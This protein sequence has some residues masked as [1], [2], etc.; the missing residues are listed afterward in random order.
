MAISINTPRIWSGERLLASNHPAPKNQAPIKIPNPDSKIHALQHDDKVLI[1]FNDHQKFLGG[2]WTKVRTN[3]RVAVTH[4]EGFTWRRAFT[5]ED[6]ME[7]GVRYSYPTMLVSGCTLIVLY[8]VT[9]ERCS[10]QCGSSDRELLP[11]ESE[12]S[13]SE[14]GIRAAIF[15]LNHL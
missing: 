1:A 11:I 4:D 14:R 12:P 6:R 15:D 9:F 7:R 5:I 2:G 3:L 10:A 8:S 13:I